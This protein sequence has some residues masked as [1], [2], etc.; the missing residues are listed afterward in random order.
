MIGSG[1][2]IGEDVVLTA[3]HN[4]WSRREQREHFNLKFFPNPYRESSEHIEVE[5]YCMPDS[6][7]RVVE[8]D[9]WHTNND[10]ALLKLKKKVVLDQYFTLCTDF[11]N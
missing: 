5:R 6:F 3:A 8:G 11:Y 2:L 1:F 10:F 4:L 9:R 7:K